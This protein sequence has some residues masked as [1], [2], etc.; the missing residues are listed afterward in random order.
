MITKKTALITGASA[1]IGRAYA[2]QLAALGYDLVVTARREERLRELA[3]TL[4]DRHRTH[5]R[6]LACDLADP[7]SP[8]HLFEQTHREGIAI[9]YLVNNAG[10][11]LPGA[12]A[13]TRW[14]DQRDFLNVMVHAV[15]ELTHRFLPPMV[16]R[17]QGRIVNVASLAGL[18][19]GS[20]GNTL[21]S[22]VKA[23]MIK[24]SESLALEL[25]GSDVNV[26]AVCPG[27]TYSEFH[28]VSGTRDK[29]SKLPKMMWMGADEVV[30]ESIAAA[31]R[32]DAVFV[33]GRVN[34][35]LSSFVRLL[36]PSVALGM[37]GR[38]SS[39]FRRDP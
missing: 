15:A 20:R 19:P 29:V 22:A 1:G 21:Y 36:P 31:E 17:G 33:N 2:E 35:A 23:F 4:S 3:T 38:S 5:V 14:Q 18:L 25:A 30:R 8:A 7:G 11:G 28:D 12:Y 10:Y 13:V 34:R 32:G 9:D 16:E 37:M 6:I 26:T 27:F 39:R 24:M